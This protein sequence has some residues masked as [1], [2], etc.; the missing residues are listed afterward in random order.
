MGSPRSSRD[1]ADERSKEQELMKS[2]LCSVCTITAAVALGWLAAVDAASQVGSAAPAL[3]R[4]ATFLEFEDLPAAATHGNKAAIVKLARKRLQA[5]PLTAAAIPAAVGP[6]GNS[7]E[8]GGVSVV[9]LKLAGT[10][11]RRV[12]K[13]QLQLAT[14]AAQ[15]GDL[16]DMLMHV[17]RALLVDPSLQDRLLPP[18]IPALADPRFRIALRPFAGR[19]WLWNFGRMAAEVPGSEVHAAHLFWELGAAQGRAPREFVRVVIRTFVSSGDIE[20]AREF[21]LKNGK[22]QPSQLDAF[23]PTKENSNPDYVPLTWDVAD[24][25]LALVELGPAGQWAASIE[26][27]RQAWL[28]KRTTSFAPGNYRAEVPVQSGSEPVMVTVRV[29]CVPASSRAAVKVLTSLTPNETRRLILAPEFP[30][31]CSS[32]DWAIEASAPDARMP[33]SLMGAGKII[34]TRRTL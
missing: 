17:D 20:S 2:V 13:V 27:G 32:Q 28:F 3:L 29:A 5:E 19:T 14:L 9:A 7:T 33:A 12:P 22:L 4:R 16:T 1:W 25:E 18:L 26:A 30:A 21:V 10:V 6:V 15:A 34:V 23:S 24:N 8:S 11:S 31:D